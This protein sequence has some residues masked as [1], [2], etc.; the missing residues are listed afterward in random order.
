MDSKW[1]ESVGSGGIYGDSVSFLRAEIDRLTAELDRL[2]AELAA[3]KA[4]ERKPMRVIRNT[5]GEDTLISYLMDDEE[6]SDEQ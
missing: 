2:R 4:N 1:Q 6:D 5:L 3:A